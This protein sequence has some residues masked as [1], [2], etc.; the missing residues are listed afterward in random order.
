MCHG[1]STVTYTACL[2]LEHI[3]TE[4]LPLYTDTQP[5]L[6]LRYI[7]DVISMVSPDFNLEGFLHFLNSLYPTLT[8][9]HEWE[10]DGKISFLDVL[11]HNLGH[12]LQFSVYRKPTH[13]NSYLHYFS[14]SHNSIK[15]GLVQSLFLRAYRVCSDNFL[16]EEIN[17]ITNSLK[18]LAYPEKIL[19][20]GL[21]KA[22]RTFFR[23]KTQV[24]FNDNIV[25]VSRPS[26]L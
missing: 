7:D 9:T 23:S 11:I 14:F 22:K 13:S 12:C 16:T 17:F 3:E 18:K 21:S 20:K 24:N 6:F 15:L 1:V 4:I 2:F 8:F 5:S 19:N 10:T 26:H 25:P